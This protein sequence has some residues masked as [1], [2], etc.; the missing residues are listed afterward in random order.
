MLYWGEDEGKEECKT[1]KRSRWKQKGHET[2]SDIEKQQ[3][4]LPAKVLR[5]FP[6]IPRL[7]RMFMSSKIV[8]SMVW[9]IEHNN[10][11]GLMRH[12]RDSKAWKTF[13]LKYL[14]FALNPQNVRLALASDSFNPFGS[15]SISYSIWPLVITPYNTPPWMCM[16]QTNFILSSIIHGK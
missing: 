1:C 11:D 9:H 10:N 3:N 7:K 4:K 12:P 13:D 15:L 8:K 16:K 6:L 14:D 5:Y 2:T